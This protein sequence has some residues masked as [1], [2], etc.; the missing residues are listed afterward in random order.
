MASY[1]PQPISLLANGISIH[2]Y[3]SVYTIPLSPNPKCYILTL[4]LTLTLKTQPQPKLLKIYSTLLSTAYPRHTKRNDDVG[5]IEVIVLPNLPTLQS[6]WIAQGPV[7]VDNVNQRKNFNAY[8]HAKQ[9]RPNIIQLYSP[10]PSEVSR[11][12]AHIK[13]DTSL[14]PISDTLLL[15]VTSRLV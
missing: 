13:L 10:N 11:L 14:A 9:S 7:V 1:I 12:M 2:L 4:T 5:T 6:L 3:W 15:C 8:T